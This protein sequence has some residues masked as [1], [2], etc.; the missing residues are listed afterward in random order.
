MKFPVP[1]QTQILPAFFPA[2]NRSLQ[3]KLLVLKGIYRE[4]AG[5]WHTNKAITFRLNFI[6][7]YNFYSL[8][9]ITIR[10]FLRNNL[11][12][13]LLRGRSHMTSSRFGHFLPPLP[14][15]RHQSSSFENPPKIS[16]VNFYDDVITVKPP[17]PTSRQNTLIFGLEIAFLFIKSLAIVVIPSRQLFI[18]LAGTILPEERESVFSKL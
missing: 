11:Y 7:H 14:P 9:F 8:A 6:M 17:P 12:K 1:A 4:K 5:I 10:S 2:E 15:S 13:Y 3:F 18:F 16:E